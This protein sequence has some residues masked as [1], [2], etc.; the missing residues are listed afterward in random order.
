M[1][2]LYTDKEIVEWFREN[3]EH[4]GDDKGFPVY[5]HRDTLTKIKLVGKTFKIYLNKQNVFNTTAAAKLF[6]YY[7]EDCLIVNGQWKSKLS[8]EQ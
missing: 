7:G 2:P 3:T 4:F 1:N 5:L 8:K 6:D